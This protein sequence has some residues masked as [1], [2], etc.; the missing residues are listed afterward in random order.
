M[1]VT[2]ARLRGNMRAVFAAFGVAVLAA[3]PIL[4]ADAVTPL[5]A[6]FAPQAL[7]QRTGEDVV[8]RGNH[9]FDRRMP[10]A[11]LETADPIISKLRGAI[12]RVNLPAG[13]KLIA[14]TFD[15]C[16]QQ[17][18]IAGY[19]GAIF[20]Y[21]RANRI[22]ATLFAGGKWMRS[23]ATRA[24]QLML[25]PLFEIASHSDTHRN[26]R[27]IDADAVASEIRGPQQTFLSL[28]AGLEKRQCVT[29]T[30][31]RL[32]NV[33]PRIGLFRFPF[34]ACNSATLDAVNDAGLLAIQWD[35][36]TG[37]PAKGQTAEAIANAM[38]RN[39]RAGSIIISHANGRGWNTAEALPLAIP[40]LKAMGFSFVT[41]SELLA[42]G[43]P[44]IADTCY[45]AKPGDTDRYD[46]LFS[47]AKKP[48][49]A[50]LPTAK[51][52]A[53]PVQLHNEP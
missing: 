36:S 23:H 50:T 9:T 17:G 12:R 33:A 40:K 5:S 52:S 48:T 13:K 31:L 43:T 1:V 4:A 45:N 29:Q 37:D 35:V 6:C 22:A 38:V 30:A 53:P 34:G 28:R 3:S 39:T 41:V 8:Q 24:E 20:D 2:M 25:D 47:I 32:A 46:T 19:D 42:S 11:T 49:G 7:Q 44:V 16:E 26:L 14:L 21:L 18:E 51:H 10:I 15:L 27:I